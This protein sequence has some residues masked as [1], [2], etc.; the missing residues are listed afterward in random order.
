MPFIFRL[1]VALLIVSNIETVAHN[2]AKV[3]KAISTDKASVEQQK[4]G[5]FAI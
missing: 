4:K 5:G 2:I 3:S 1:A